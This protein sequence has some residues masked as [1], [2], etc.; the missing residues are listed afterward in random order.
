MLKALAVI[1]GLLVC[2]PDVSSAEIYRCDSGDGV[3]FADEPCGPGAEKITVQDNRIGGNFGQNLPVE[4]DPE[5]SP[6]PEKQEDQADSGTCRYI[7]STALRRYIIREQVVKGMTQE[8]VIDAFGKP[9]EIYPAPQETW[10]YQTTYYGA[11]YE[12]TYVYFRDGC[13][14][15]VVYR[16]P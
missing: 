1:A 10:V 3:R 7:N 9:P 4:P 16:K 11:I 2:W 5:P 13:V 12:L 8:H 6:E 14:E 15:K